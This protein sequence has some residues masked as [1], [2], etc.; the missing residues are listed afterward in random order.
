MSLEI[1]F[2]LRNKLGNVRAHAILIVFAVH[3]SV[4]NYKCKAL[5]AEEISKLAFAILVFIAHPIDEW[6]NIFP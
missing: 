2:C 5:Y 1:C 4:V 3:S 6:R